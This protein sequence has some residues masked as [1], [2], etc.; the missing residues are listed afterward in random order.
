MSIV[1]KVDDFNDSK[2][3]KLQMKHTLNRLALLTSSIVVSSIYKKHFDGFRLIFF[4]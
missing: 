3:N 2:I 4:D 1:E